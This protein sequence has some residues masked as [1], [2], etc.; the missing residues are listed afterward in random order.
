MALRAGGKMFNRSNTSLN[1]EYREEIVQRVMLA[2]GTVRVSR[3]RHRVVKALTYAG[4][5]L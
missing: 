4:R 5:V 1:S 3:I 2:G